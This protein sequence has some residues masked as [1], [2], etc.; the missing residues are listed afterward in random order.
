MKALGYVRGEARDVELSHVGTDARGQPAL[1]AAEAALAFGRMVA[2]A[3]RDGVVIVINSAFRTHAEQTSLW[4]RYEVQLA[5]WERAG[6]K[7]PRPL[8]PSR[9]GHSL[10]ESGNA[11]DL[12]MIGDDGR[13]RPAAAWLRAHAREYGYVTDVAR[14]PWHHTYAPSKEAL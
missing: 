12:D 11:I 9:P 3:A 14:E 1:L 13:E 6:K 4:R 10:H 5:T 2:A 7:G 8:R